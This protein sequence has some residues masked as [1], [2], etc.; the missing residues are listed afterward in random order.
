MGLLYEK[1]LIWVSWIHHA[2]CN[3]LSSSKINRPCFLISFHTF[4]IVNKFI[5]Y[6][7]NFMSYSIAR[8]FLHKLF[9]RSRI[10]LDS[11][12]GE[13][14]FSWFSRCIIFTESSLLNLSNSR[15]FRSLRSYSMGLAAS[16]S[17]IYSSSIFI[18]LS[19]T[20][21]NFF[22]ICWK[23][24]LALFSITFSANFFDLDWTILF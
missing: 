2:L 16:G 20:G 9:F 8:I 23:I 15:Y 5:G 7:M 21:N 13:L 18:F 12:S 10:F 19:E 11:S 3:L 22:Y 17:L 24:S 14:K 1:H 6:F 4:L